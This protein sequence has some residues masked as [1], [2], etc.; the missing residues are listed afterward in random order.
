MLKLMLG[1][2]KN[3]KFE[4]NS[5]R[6]EQMKMKNRPGYSRLRRGNSGMSSIDVTGAINFGGKTLKSRERTNPYSEVWNRRSMEQPRCIGHLQ[7]Q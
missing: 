7:Q 4:R 5:D 3:K 6:E 2:I 1:V